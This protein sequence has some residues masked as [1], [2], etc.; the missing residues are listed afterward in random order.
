MA[1]CS[2]P[3]L[4]RGFLII[5]NGDNNNSSGVPV[6]C[7]SLVPVPG[8]P[9][10]LPLLPPLGPGERVPDPLFIGF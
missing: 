10:P 5:F 2:L 7:L 3:P 9:C 8:R 1:A 4:P 6:S